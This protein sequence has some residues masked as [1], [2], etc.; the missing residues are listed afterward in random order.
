MIGHLVDVE[1]DRARD[2][3]GEIFRRGVAL[4]GRQIIRAVDHDEVG[5]AQ[6]GGEPV[7]GDEPA[8]DRRLGRGGGHGQVSFGCRRR[9]RVARK[10]CQ[11]PTRRH[12]YIGPRGAYAKAMRTRRFCLPFFSIWVTRT[13]PISPVRR[14]WVPPQGCRSYPAIATRRTRPVPIG[15]L[16]DMVLTRDG[17]AAS[18][19]SLIQRVVTSASAAIMS[20]SLRVISSLSRPASGMSKSSRPSDSPTEPPVTGNG[21]AADRR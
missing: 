16:T 18:S 9:R 8:A 14:T 2:M 3:A 19:S 5:R 15:G 7:G 17:L 6:P 4:V 21:K 13:V 1:A 20:A 11:I 10:R 12:R